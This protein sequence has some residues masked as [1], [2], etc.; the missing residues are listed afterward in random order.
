MTAGETVSGSR[1]QGRELRPDSVEDVFQHLV[2]HACSC[3]NQYHCKGFK[4]PFPGKGQ[5]QPQNNCY[6]CH[7]RRRTDD[8]DRFHYGGEGRVVKGGHRLGYREVE[9]LEFVLQEFLG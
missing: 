2:G 4:R 5:V 3:Q 1:D 8:S 7:D 9:W 6:A